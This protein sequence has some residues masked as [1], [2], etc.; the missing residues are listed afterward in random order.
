MLSANQPKPPEKKSSY[1]Y[2]PIPISERAELSTCT[3]AR[4]AGLMPSCWARSV[5]SEMRDSMSAGRGRFSCFTSFSE[6]EGV[7]EGG[8]TEGGAGAVMV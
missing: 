6:T 2:R 8:P 5:V 1:W 7:P 3:L 4:N